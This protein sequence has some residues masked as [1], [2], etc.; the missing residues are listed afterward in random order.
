M[1]IRLQRSDHLWLQYNRKAVCKLHI[2]IPCA[3]IDCQRHRYG[4]K[5]T[6]TIHI[7]VEESVRDRAALQ[8]AEQ[9][10]TL[11]ET[12]RIQLE[13][14]AAGCGPNFGSLTPN[15]TTAKAIEAAR[16]GELVEI[17]TPDE[18]LA[19]LNRDE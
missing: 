6:V 3:T 11:I 1:K 14:I 15:P 4:I 12:M 9:G 18:V 13:Q 10:L 2:A 17:G 19:E 16:C 8:L 7:E 5:L